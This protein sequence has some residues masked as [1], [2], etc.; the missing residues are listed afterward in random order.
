[1]KYVIL[2]ASAAG[3]NAAYVLRMLD[4][5]AEIIMI[6]EDTRIYSKCILHYYMSGKKDADGLNF[7]PPDFIEKNQI[8]WKKGIKAPAIDLENKIVDLSDGTKQDY[9][10][11]LI[12]TGSHSFVPPIEGVQGADNVCCFH[13]LEECEKLMKLAQ[14]ANH[15]V[16]LGAGL[17]GVDVACGL[18][19]QNKDITMVDMKEHMLAIQLDDEAASVYQNKFTQTG[20]KQYYNTSVA[21]VEKNAHGLVENVVLKDGTKLPC[22]LLVIA[23][24]VRANV[25]FLKDTGLELDKK[26][27]VIDKESRTNIKDI[28]GA[29]DVTGKDLIW[30]VAVKEGVVAALN[31]AGKEGHMTD[32]FYGK[33]WMNFFDIPTLS[34]GVHELPDE[35]YEQE[36]KKT[37]LK[38]YKKIIYKDKKVAG[39]ILQ[40]DLS[41]SGVLTVMIHD[42]IKLPDVKKKLLDYTGDDFLAPRS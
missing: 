34:Y 37:M 42:G 12:A 9:D 7:M 30:P 10:K 16:I 18:L 35:T 38:G 5:A 19:D 32:F 39:A 41:Y 33:S 31:M 23:A 2:G 3:V 24:G 28:Y 1:M 13:T 8:E 22:D 6:S 26:G 25:G 20:I 21:S 40:G 36:V 14:T 29:G 15:I 11:L 27:L 17:V 4:K